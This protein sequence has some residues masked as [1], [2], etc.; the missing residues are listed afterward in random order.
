MDSPDI[1]L[2]ALKS[3]CVLMEE[4]SVSRAAA[5]LGV[6]QS[7]MSR[8]LVNLRAYFADPLLVW[9]GGS[10]VPTP[11]ALSLK[12]EINQI[13]ATME[14]LSTATQSFD[15]A[16]TESTVVLV[17]TGYMEHVF[18]TDVMKTVAERAARM[19]VKIRLPDRLDD[20]GAMERGEIDFLV[21]WMTTPAPILRSRL[22]FKDKLVCIARRAHPGLSEDSHLSYEK[23]VELPHVQYEIP[24]KT[25]TERLLEERLSRDGQRRNIKYH[26]QTPLSV[27]RL[28]ADSDLI[29]T[30]PARFAAHCLE[31]YPLRVLDLPF[32]L[33]AVQNRVYWHECMHSDE[34]NRWFRALLAE[35]AKAD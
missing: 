14:R 27:A 17:A 4:R 7:S 24:G 1:D 9:A 10:M 15:P 18:L 2:S 28:V 21:G 8:R 16:S 20:I 12:S 13:V 5:R 31:H 11:R 26:V 35:T 25:T 22:L 30:V 32:N 3:F 33:P 29:A 19:H 6:R 34:H 23:Y